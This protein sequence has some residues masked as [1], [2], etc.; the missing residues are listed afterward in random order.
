M[1]FPNSQ[2]EFQPAGHEREHKPPSAEER[3][4]ETDQR[5]CGFEQA[6]SVAWASVF[7][8]LRWDTELNHKT[9][10]LKYLE[11]PQMLLVT[12]CL[13]EIGTD[14]SPVFLSLFEYKMPKAY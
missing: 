2:R 4:Q 10:P 7:S 9:L 6:A 5:R 3:P 14:F 13:A 1:A 12:L 11:F 8:P